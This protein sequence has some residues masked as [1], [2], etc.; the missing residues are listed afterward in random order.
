MHRSGAIIPASPNTRGWRYHLSGVRRYNTCAKAESVARLSHMFGLP[1]GNWEKTAKVGLFIE[2]GFRLGT[3][4][5]HQ[6]VFGLVDAFEF[7]I[8]LSSDKTP[9]DLKLFISAIKVK[10]RRPTKLSDSHTLS[11]IGKRHSWKPAVL[12]AKA[13]ISDFWKLEVDHPYHLPR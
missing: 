8:L 4:S 11:F 10:F 12:T 6:W 1:R 7:A 5:I 2:I 9:K 13:T 3:Y